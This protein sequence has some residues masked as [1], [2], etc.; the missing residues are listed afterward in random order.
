MVKQNKKSERVTKTRI[1]VGNQMSQNQNTDLA[2]TSFGV[3][4]WFGR[5]WRSCGM[6]RLVN[7]RILVTVEL[8]IKYR[9][10]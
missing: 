9:R 7:V 4:I 2:W 1:K 5:W 10:F 8:M 3:H 6:N